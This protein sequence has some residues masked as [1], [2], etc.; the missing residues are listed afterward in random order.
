VEAGR[1]VHATLA[2]LE[3]RLRELSAQLERGGAAGDSATGALV[4]AGPIAGAGAL[5]RFVE[6]L[7]GLEGV[8]EVALRGLEGDRALVDVRLAPERR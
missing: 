8:Q 6:A 7:R 4:S 1:D 3:R 5:E 2:E